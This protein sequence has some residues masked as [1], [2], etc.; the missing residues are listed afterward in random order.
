MSTL[1]ALM[2]IV[3]FIAGLFR[4]RRWAFARLIDTTAVEMITACAVI[5]FY[6]CLAILI[7]PVAGLAS[8]TVIWGASYL[9]A[10]ALLTIGLVVLV[11]LLRR[12][13]TNG[14]DRV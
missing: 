9:I 4:V 14:A 8:W 5:S 6:W 1:F 2:L 12:R 3:G 13:T 11:T 10:S 7:P